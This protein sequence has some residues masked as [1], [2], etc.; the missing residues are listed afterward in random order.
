MRDL[1]KR[2]REG[3]G[4]SRVDEDQNEVRSLAKGLHQGY[5]D[6]N[7]VGPRGNRSSSRL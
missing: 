3:N 1:G 7:E 4:L 5:E 2:G 6:Q